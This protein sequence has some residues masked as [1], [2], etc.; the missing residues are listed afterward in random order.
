MVVLSPVFTCRARHFLRE[1]MRLMSK[2]CL[3]YALPK[4]EPPQDIVGEFLQAPTVREP[5]TVGLPPFR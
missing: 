1:C 4:G 5:P 3:Y 2:T